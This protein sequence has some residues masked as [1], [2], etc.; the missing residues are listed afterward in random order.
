[1]DRVG[2]ENDYHP[3]D[4][5]HDRQFHRLDPFPRTA[6]SPFRLIRLYPTQ[7]AK[8]APNLIVSLTRKEKRH[9][10]PDSSDGKGKTF[11]K[12]LK[13]NKG[14]DRKRVTSS[15]AFSHRCKSVTDRGKGSLPKCY[16]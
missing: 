2:F 13:K 8:T 10:S 1:M 3:D 14:E 15:L 4:R 6:G 12:D 5:D 11:N 7:S 16:Y 9:L